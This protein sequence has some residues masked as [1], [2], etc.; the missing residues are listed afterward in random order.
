MILYFQIFTDAE[1]WSFDDAG[2]YQHTFRDMVSTQVNRIKFIQSLMTFM[3]KYG[4][5]GADI[6]WEYPVNKTHGGRNSDSTL[7]G[8]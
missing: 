4:F 8:G 5:Q 3:D 7:S 1:R 6:D 2:Q